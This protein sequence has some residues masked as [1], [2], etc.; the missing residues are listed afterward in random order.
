LSKNDQTCIEMAKQDIW[1]TLGVEKPEIFINIFITGEHSTGKT[2][3]V[4][5]FVGQEFSADYHR[6]IGV[7]IFTKKLEMDGDD[8]SLACW[9]MAGDERWNENRWNELRQH[10]IEGPAGALIVGD[11]SRKHTVSIIPEFYAPDMKEQW[12]ETIPIL[13][14]AN[15]RDLPR[16]VSAEDLE[17][18]KNVVGAVGVMETSAKSGDN[19]TDAFITLARIVLGR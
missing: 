19:A 4:R 7:N 18:C 1:D 17:E 11:L 14:I 2:S 8:V 3:L 12:G 15:K 6:T 10:Y 13:L 9:D 16:K 5:A